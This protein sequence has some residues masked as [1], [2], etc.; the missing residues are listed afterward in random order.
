MIKEVN[1]VEKTKHVFFVCLVI[2]VITLYIG[3]LVFAVAH[4]QGEEFDFKA[5]FIGIVV[6]YGTIGLAELGNRFGISLHHHHHHAEHDCD[7][8]N[9][10]GH[11]H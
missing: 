11:K 9:T 10:P 5:F 8:H 6:S 7:K 4:L 3:G 2:G 1:M